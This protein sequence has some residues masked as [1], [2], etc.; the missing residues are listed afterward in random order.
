MELRV[1]YI[2]GIGSISTFNFIEIAGQ[3]G[4]DDL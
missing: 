1:I 3:A 4:N 2:I